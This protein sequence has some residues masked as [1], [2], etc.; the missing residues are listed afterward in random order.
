LRRLETRGRFFAFALLA[1][2]NFRDF[3][4]SNREAMVVQKNSPRSKKLASFGHI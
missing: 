4:V 2:F 1:C 3:E